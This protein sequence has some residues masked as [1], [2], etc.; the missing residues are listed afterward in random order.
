MVEPT[1]H[2]IHVVKIT[3]RET[4][5]NH[6]ASANS[7]G[8]SEIQ[9]LALMEPRRWLLN[10]SIRVGDDRGRG[11]KPTPRHQ[12]KTHEKLFHRNPSIVA[13]FVA[14]A[15]SIKGRPE[16]FSMKLA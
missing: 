2:R 3:L 15:F 12:Q 9:T 7:E 14:G 11:F 4:D 16:F 10:P 6:T 5:P 13:V 8:V 1:H